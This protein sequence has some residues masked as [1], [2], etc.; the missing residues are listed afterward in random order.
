LKKNVTDAVGTGEAGFVDERKG[1][2][3]NGVWYRVTAVND[4][5]MSESSIV[6]RC[7]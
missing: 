6:V 3:G 7:E 5:G 1:G 4:F 2:G